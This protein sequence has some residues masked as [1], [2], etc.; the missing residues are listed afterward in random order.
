MRQAPGES[1]ES[2]FAAAA[3]LNEDS[4]DG[5]AAAA[6]NPESRQ[7]RRP[8]SRST[9]WRGDVRGGDS[10]PTSHAASALHRPASRGSASVNWRHGAESEGAVDRQRP[11]PHS[12]SS[13]RLARTEGSGGVVADAS[14]EWR[15]DDEEAD[16]I[17]SSVLP[18]ARSVLDV[19][20]MRE[21]PVMEPPRR[22]VSAVACGECTVLFLRPEH[23]HLLHHKGL[24]VELQRRAQRA[25]Q[26]IDDR[27][28]LA[29]R[30][31]ELHTKAAVKMLRNEAYGPR[32]TRSVEH[33]VVLVPETEAEP[34]RKPS[35]L[36]VLDLLA[37]RDSSV[38]SPPPAASA[39]PLAAA[40]ASAGRS[41]VSTTAARR[42]M[43]VSSPVS[44]LTSPGHDRGRTQGA[45]SASMTLL[46]RHPH[47]PR[48]TA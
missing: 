12:R 38:L 7:S 3:G 25:Q 17:H 48:V 21:G 33:G 43:H 6:R 22:E 47:L 4:D 1:C 37:S 39:L 32:Y 45:S 42:S 44:L 11:R 15:L 35:T 31:G 41:N 40:T 29:R 13:F 34:G 27:Q 5:T 26:R 24:F 30:H 20:L 9:S 16:S 14:A 8:A 28:L 2:P 23:F 36:G 19:M 46:R 18:T 10:P